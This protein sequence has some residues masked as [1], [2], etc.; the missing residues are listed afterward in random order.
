MN[1]RC[2]TK[3]AREGPYAAEVDVELIVAEGGWEPYLSLDDAHRLDEVREARGAA[4]S[5]RHRASPACS[6]SRRSR[7]ESRRTSACSGIVRTTAILRLEV[8]DEVQ[9]RA[10]QER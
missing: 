3:L 1:K 10:A 9:D 5:E 7:H 2:H 6:A 8:S 4:I